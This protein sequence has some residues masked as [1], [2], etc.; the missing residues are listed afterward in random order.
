MQNCTTNSGGTRFLGAVWGKMGH[1]SFVLS[2]TMKGYSNCRSANS[3]TDF[4]R[5]PAILIVFASVDGVFCT[6]LLYGR[7]SKKR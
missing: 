2:Q 4:E 5:L 6:F 1:A 3:S 7:L